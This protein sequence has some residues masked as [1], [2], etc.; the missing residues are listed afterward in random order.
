MCIRL[1]VA[2]IL[3]SLP[4]S[5]DLRADA[6]SALNR[7]V[8]FYHSISTHGGYLWRYSADL[9]ERWG[10]GKATPTQVWV[11]HPGT[12]AVGQAFLRAYQITEDPNHLKFAREA[13]LALSYG[14]LESG[15]WDYRID[16]DPSSSRWYR[17]ADVGKI[18]V[19]AIRNRRNNT[20]FDDDNTQSAIRFLLAFVQLTRD[21]KDSRDVP[22]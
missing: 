5:A 15:G 1:F 2:T 19:S 9:S 12:P 17:R 18:N 3:I 6:L 8:S 16:F 11:Q 21:S 14:Q 4:A 20:V 13:A 10:E 22:I 7:S